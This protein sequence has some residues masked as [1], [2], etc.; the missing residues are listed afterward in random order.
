MRKARANTRRLDKTKRAI[1]LFESFTTAPSLV[2][3]CVCVVCMCVTVWLRVL[4]NR[5]VCVCGIIVSRAQL[6]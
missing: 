5:V 2:A 3:A 4:Y 6:L 1:N